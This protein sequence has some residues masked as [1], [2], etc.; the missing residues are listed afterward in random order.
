MRPL[1]FLLALVLGGPLRA[2]GATY[3]FTWQGANGYALTGAMSFDPA[4]IGQRLVREQDVSCFVIE[5]T[6][7]GRPVGRWMLGMLG[8]DTSW[9]LFF[10][11]VA[12]A[13]V[14]EGQGVPMPQA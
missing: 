11:P 2:D 14:V 3:T 10:D 4:L 9:R 7:D 12:S 8:P 13:F 1:V 5:G 6:R